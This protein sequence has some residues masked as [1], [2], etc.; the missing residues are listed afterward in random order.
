MIFFSASICWPVYNIQLNYTVFLF[1]M[2]S[3]KKSA[4]PFL[5]KVYTFSLKTQCNFISFTLA[6]KNDLLPFIRE[7]MREIT[8]NKKRKEK[9]K[10]KYK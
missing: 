8:G 2:A 1:A 3:G 6:I 5:R 7:R 10:K 4:R 9:R